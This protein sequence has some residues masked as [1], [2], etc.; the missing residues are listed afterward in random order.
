M[1]QINVPRLPQ[2]SEEYDP[3]QINQLITTIDL[4]IQILNTS[5]T[6]EQLRAEE[7]AV[8]WFMAD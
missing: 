3:S 2:A 7:E 1:A 4:L 5:Y 6:P 8:T